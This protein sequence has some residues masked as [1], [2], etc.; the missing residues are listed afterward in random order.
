MAV[1][2]ASYKFVS[3]ETLIYLTS[4]ISVAKNHL[5]SFDLEGEVKDI[6]RHLHQIFNHCNRLVWHSTH[7]SLE[8]FKDGQPEFNIEGNV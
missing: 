4:H 6:S 5:F 2:A 7:M 3:N 8:L 1:S